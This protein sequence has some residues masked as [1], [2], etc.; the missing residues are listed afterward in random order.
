MAKLAPC[1]DVFR[2]TVEGRESV[3]A[4]HFSDGQP[5]YSLESIP[6]NA[7]PDLSLLVDL[8]RSDTLIPREIRDW[9]ADLFDPNATTDFPFKELARRKPGKPEK[10]LSRNWDAAAFFDALCE[11]G[12]HRKAAIAQ[13][14]AKFALAKTVLEEAIRSYRVASEEHARVL[15]EEDG[16]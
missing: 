12:I 16:A 11:E 14:M 3:V 9:L 7:N 8:F 1:W 6:Q 4:C 5:Y 13:T 10:A 15:R 2:D